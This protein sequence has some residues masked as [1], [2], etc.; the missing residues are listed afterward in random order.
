MPPKKTLPRNLTPLRQIYFF[1]G[2]PTRVS[3]HQR[4]PHI[5]TRNGILTPESNTFNKGLWFK[6]KAL[7]P[8]LATRWRCRTESVCV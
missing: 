2:F 7:I 8:K 5:I 4:S 6:S 1:L 3:S